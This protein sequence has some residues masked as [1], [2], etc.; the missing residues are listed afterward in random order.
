M[1]TRRLR[2]APSDS[3]AFYNIEQK[4]D[5]EVSFIAGKLGLTV[6][7]DDSLGSTMMMMM[8][9]RGHCMSIDDG[10]TNVSN[11]MFND[12]VVLIMVNSPKEWI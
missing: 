12:D 2:V 7:C 10:V 3:L 1:E 9:M 8:M 4:R 11:I 6:S 5:Q